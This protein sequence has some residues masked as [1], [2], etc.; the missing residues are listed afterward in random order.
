M[1]SHSPD[2]ILFNT[3]AT[4]LTHLKNNRNSEG[5]KISAKFNIAL[6]LSK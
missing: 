3:L 2:Y 1:D 6:S 5:N 4:F